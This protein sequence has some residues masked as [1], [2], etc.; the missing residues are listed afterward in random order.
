MAQETELGGYQLVGRLA[1]G[2]MAEVYQAKPLHMAFCLD[3]HRNP[4]AFLRPSDKVTDLNW[5]WSEDPKEAALKQKQFG[6]KAVHD[7]K[8]QSMENCSACHR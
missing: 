8:V 4:G 3:C 7:W 5:K 6:D 2:G 1:V